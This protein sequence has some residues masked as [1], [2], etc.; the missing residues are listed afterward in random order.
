MQ[1]MVVEMHVSEDGLKQKLWALSE[2]QAAGLIGIFR[3]AMKNKTKQK[4]EESVSILKYISEILRFLAESFK[5]ENLDWKMS[6][7]IYDLF[8][9]YIL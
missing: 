7:L 1:Q 8:A 4:I 9:D 3:T 5:S 2:D 6:K